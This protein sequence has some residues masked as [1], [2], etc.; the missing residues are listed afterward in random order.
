MAEVFPLKEIPRSDGGC[1]IVEFTNDDYLGV[2]ALPN[3]LPDDWS[4]FDVGHTFASGDQVWYLGRLYSCD[5]QH[6]KTATNNPD[7][8]GNWQFVGGQLTVLSGSA[9]QDPI[10]NVTQ[11]EFSLNISSGLSGSNISLQS[12]AS[13]DRADY[14]FNLDPDDFVPAQS[15]ITAQAARDLIDAAVDA[16]GDGLQATGDGIIAVGNPIFHTSVLLSGQITNDS[17]TLTLAGYSDPIEYSW[18]GTTYVRI[19]ADDGSD[20]RLYRGTD[21]TDLVYTKTY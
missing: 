15:G 1:S 19:F 16:Q 8:T 10:S 4:E 14:T 5:A 7:A 3:V 9:G 18:E 17:S 21:F 2:S 11:L 6:N 13:G 12:N 20:E